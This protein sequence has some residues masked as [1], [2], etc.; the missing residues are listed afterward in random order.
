MV[1]IN[2]MECYYEA[3]EDR[4]RGFFA[5]WKETKQNEA[6]YRMLVHALLEINQRPDA[7]NICKLL[8]EDEYSMQTNAGKFHSCII[9]CTFSLSYIRAYSYSNL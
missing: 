8:A 5:T 2:D 1:V 6:T 7:E 4:R 3:E 9:L